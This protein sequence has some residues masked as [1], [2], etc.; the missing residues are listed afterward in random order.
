[1]NVITP[2]CSHQDIDSIFAGG[3]NNYLHEGFST[4][5]YSCTFYDFELV[6]SGK[7]LVYVNNEVIEV[8]RGDLYIVPPRIIRNKVIL[9]EGSSTSY[10]AVQL[11]ELGRYMNNLNFSSSVFV[12]R[13]SNTSIRYLENVIDSLEQYRFFE[14]R[15]ERKQRYAYKQGKL[16]SNRIPNEAELRQNG[17]FSLFISQL[18]HDH[19]EMRKSEPAQLSKDEYVRKA[20]HFIKGNYKDDISVD[21]VAQNIGLHRSYLY[22]LFQQY[23]GVSVC[24]Y[25]IQVR[26]EAACDLLRQRNIPIKVVALSVGYSPITFT[27][28]FKKCMGITATEY[29]K[30]HAKTEEDE[31]ASSMPTV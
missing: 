8:Q 9:E 17:L 1:M 16:W 29:Q 31:T 20:M 5:D 19:G 15:S 2:E 30:I 14:A 18:L 27:R 26:I 25:I 13:P 3:R 23:A 12:C 22:T 6:T 28:A 11:P 7:F 10:L 4:G 24:D 21:T